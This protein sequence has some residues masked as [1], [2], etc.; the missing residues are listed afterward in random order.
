MNV[1][2]L[3][4][5]ANVEAARAGA[6]IAF[7]TQPTAI[8]V[9]VFVGVVATRGNGQIAVLQIQRDI[10]LP[11][12]GHIDVDDVVLI[13]LPNIGVHHARLHGRTTRNGMIHVAPTFEERIV[14]QVGEH[15]V[16]HQRRKHRHNRYSFNQRV[17]RAE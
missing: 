14:E 4:V 3:H 9:L 12:A 16:I 1:G 10:V 11:E 17:A 5:L 2:I 15:R 13:G 8:A 6:G 7:T